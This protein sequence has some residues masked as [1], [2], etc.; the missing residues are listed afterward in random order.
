MADGK[1]W[2]TPSIC[3]E[4]VLIQKLSE[5]EGSRRPGLGIPCTHSRA[6][7]RAFSLTPA[8]K[9]T[10]AWKR[11]LGREKKERAWAVGV[12]MQPLLRHKEQTSEVTGR[13]QAHNTAVTGRR[14]HDQSQA[15]KQDTT[16]PAFPLR[17]FQSHSKH[18]HLPSLLP[19]RPLHQTSGN[20]LS[21]K[22]QTTP[23]IVTQVPH[24][25]RRPLLPTQAEAGSTVKEQRMGWGAW[26]RGPQSRHLAAPRAGTRA[27]HRGGAHLPGGR[28]HPP[29][30]G[31][32][33][34]HGRPA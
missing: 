16:L 8:G 21:T 25:C 10:S 33:H 7:I 15:A 28:A 24:T 2:P 12:L 23:H 19:S 30:S 9:Q 5:P 26:S 14:P 13:C 29:W 31:S 34:P 18:T 1:W 6:Y 4:L 27:G 32:C 22:A 20:P 11:P 17:S 3:F